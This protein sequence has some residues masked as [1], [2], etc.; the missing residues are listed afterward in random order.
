MHVHML[1]NATAATKDMAA[2][3]TMPPTAIGATPAAL[4]LPRSMRRS[5]CQ[6]ASQMQF[7]CGMQNH[8]RGVQDGCGSAPR[9]ALLRFCRSVLSFGT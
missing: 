1:S 3:H 6:A 9:S 8:V 7:A 4:F 2:V 5:A